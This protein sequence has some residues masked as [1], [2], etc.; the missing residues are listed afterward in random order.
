MTARKRRDS[1]ALIRRRYGVA[2]AAFVDI[3]RGT[4]SELDWSDASF[5][6]YMT[7]PAG[8]IKP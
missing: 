7:V 2:G 8:S 6:L 1:K 3:S 5:T 4:G